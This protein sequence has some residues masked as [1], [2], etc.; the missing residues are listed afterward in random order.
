MVDFLMKADPSIV[1]SVLVL[2]VTI[3]IG[4][5]GTLYTQ[6]KT[7]ERE[8]EESHREKKIEIYQEFIEMYMKM[9]LGAKQG[10]VVGESELLEFMIKFKEN[11]ILRGSAD[12]LKAQSDLMAE[13][14][15]NNYRKMFLSMD[16][17]IK[18][19]RKDIGLSSRGLKDYFFVKMNIVDL[20]EFE[21]L[22]KK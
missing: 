21:E 19:M 11:V 7:K 12:V 3:L 4:F 9:L 17:L 8:I 10:K 14:K 1:V 5:L 2:M 22:I 16:N 15:E 20:D 6:R 18:V 13:S